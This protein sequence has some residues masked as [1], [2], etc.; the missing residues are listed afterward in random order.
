[1]ATTK[2]A[3]A[4]RSAI[5]WAGLGWM[6]LFFWYF[7]GVTQALLWASGTTG[8][9]GSRQALLASALWLVPLLLFPGRTRLLAGAIGAVL[10]L[11]SLSGF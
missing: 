9:T 3:P 10:W 8:S 6:F 5:D 1:M 4:G 11:C 7:S 2:S